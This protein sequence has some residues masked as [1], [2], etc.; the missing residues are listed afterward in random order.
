MPDSNI[1]PP[2][3]VDGMAIDRPM[4][5]TIG[6][7]TLALLLFPFGVMLIWAKVSQ[8]L[9]GLREGQS[10][11]TLW[12][13]VAGICAAV[14]SPVM[15]AHLL[16]SFWVRNR[17]IIAFDRLQIVEHLGG[18]DVV[19][20][21]IPFANIASVTYDA[22]EGQVGINLK[23]PDDPGTYVGSFL[24]FKLSMKHCGRHFCITNEY[25][26]GPEAIAAEIE[27]EMKRWSGMT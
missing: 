13:L 11:I 4:G 8:E 10:E 7:A 26:G 25:R 22:T 23:D 9:N 21:Q 1:S 16:R 12:G 17:V 19:L 20:L 5:K 14:S 15:V 18:K 3:P 6:L 24:D 2:V 27:R